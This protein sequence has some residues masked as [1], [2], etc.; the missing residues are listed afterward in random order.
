M[1]GH[2]ESRDPAALPSGVI[3]VPGAPPDETTTPFPV[4]LR[5]S[6]QSTIASSVVNILRSSQVHGAISFC[7]EDS[8]PAPALGCRFKAAR[9]RC[10]KRSSPTTAGNVNE[11]FRPTDY[12]AVGIIF[13]VAQFV[14]K[15]VC[16][17][18]IFKN[19]FFF[20]RFI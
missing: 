19:F 13:V 3:G 12:R 15:F 4:I 1:F 6:S 11:T 10:R 17:G 9:T 5:T 14:N 7:P 2:Q 20:Y 16:S 8:F 18:L